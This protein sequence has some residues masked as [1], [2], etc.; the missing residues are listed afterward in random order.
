MRNLI[1]LISSLC[2]SVINSR[3]GTKLYFRKIGL[4]ILALSCSFTA[5]ATSFVF[6]LRGSD[7]ALALD[8]QSTGQLGNN[9]LIATFVAGPGAA[10]DE[11]FNQTATRFGI[12]SLGTSDDSSSLI[13]AADGVSELL[14][15]SFSQV[16]KLDQ[17]ILSIFAPGEIAGLSIA[18]ATPLLLNGLSDALDVYDFSA[19]TLD[20]GEQ[21]L[22]S[23]VSGNGFSFDSFTVSSVQVPEPSVLVL[24]FVGVIGLFVF[25]LRHRG[26]A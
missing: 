7:A 10:V 22:L 25:G 18:G 4:L 20:I 11:I 3:S 13:D 6:D 19:S 8:G 14:S 5:Q 2:V 1:D 9:S 15:I 23:H 26:Q 16:V 24:M 17:I 21:I 12:N